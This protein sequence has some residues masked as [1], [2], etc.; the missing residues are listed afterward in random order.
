MTR[1]LL[2]ASLALLLA[3]CT[4]T[5]GGSGKA[6]DMRAARQHAQQ[7]A[8]YSARNQR[9]L[10][11]RELDIAIRLDAGNAD[12]LA[13]RG[14]VYAEQGESEAALRDL[15]RALE[16]KADNPGASFDRAMIYYMQGALPLALSDI[17]HAVRLS[18]DNPRILGARCV[19]GAAVGEADSALGYCNRALGLQQGRE[20]AYIALGQ[21][22]LILNR[23][24][25]ALAAFQSALTLNP[26]LARA[27]YG[28]GL[29]KQRLGDKTG[30][31]D[32]RTA[33]T[34]LPGAGREFR[35]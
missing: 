23:N 29:A 1:S 16:L 33:T 12:Y 5:P 20:N 14:H 35:L 4:S 21:A 26:Y 24:P 19:I 2:A 13:R 34:R 9:V 3:A 28:L 18:H 6:A 11:L 15:N 7:A 8:D 10:A 30:E 32:M 31:D 27:L 17:E 25:E 22:Y